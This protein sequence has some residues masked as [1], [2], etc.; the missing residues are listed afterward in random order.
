[1]RVISKLRKR[2]YRQ[3][4]APPFNHMKTLH[5]D[6]RLEEIGDGPGSCAIVWKR[7]TIGRTRPLGALTPPRSAECFIVASGP[8]LADIEFARLRGRVCF[9]VNGSIVK[10]VETGV[11]FSYHAITDRTFVRNRFDL[12]RQAIRS[13]ADCLFTFRVLSHIAEREPALLGHDRLFLLTEMNAVYGV[14]QLVPAAFDA[15]AVQQDGVHLHP[16]ARLTEGRVGFSER[17]ERGVFTGQTVVFVAL[18]VCHALGFQRVFILGM[19]LGAGGTY[20]RFYERGDAATRTHLYRDFE[21]YILPSFELARHVTAPSGFEIYNL[22]PRSRLPA[23]VIPKLSFEAALAMGQDA[24]SFPPAGARATS[25]TVSDHE[26][27]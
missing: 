24:A 19:D 26:S 10:W 3:R 23:D 5:P 11:P 16:T 7:K 22:A 9:G 15:W 17:L 27:G 4:I 14:P 18:Q 2:L 25:M 20:A 12:V 8:S 13:G 1:M 6:F 21:P